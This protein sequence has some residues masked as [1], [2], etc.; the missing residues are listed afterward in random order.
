M[1]TEDLEITIKSFIVT[2][3]KKV[4]TCQSIHI[5]GLGHFK[6]FSSDFVNQP[7][8]ETVLKVQRESSFTEMFHREVLFFFW[9]RKLVL[10][11]PERE[12]SIL[13]PKIQE[14]T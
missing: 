2:D 14:K 1:D 10:S 3:P 12:T 6:S 7:G 11:S 4:F 13:R 5:P 9:Q 8:L